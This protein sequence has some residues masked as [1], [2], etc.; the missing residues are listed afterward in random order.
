MLPAGKVSSSCSTS[1]TR[2][3]TLVTNPVTSHECGRIGKRLR[4]VEHIGGYFIGKL[5]LF[6]IVQSGFDMFVLKHKL[7]KDLILIQRNLH[8]L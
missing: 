8:I 4:Q 5:L 3:I 1:G 2:H 6:L 7:T